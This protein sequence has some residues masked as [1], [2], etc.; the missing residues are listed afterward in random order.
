MNIVC[1]VSATVDDIIVK[2]GTGEVGVV[3]GVADANVEVMF[4][5]D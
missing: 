4:P 1:V 2:V 5:G 3:M